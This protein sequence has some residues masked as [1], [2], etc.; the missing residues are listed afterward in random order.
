MGQEHIVRQALG[1]YYSP[2][3]EGKAD[4]VGLYNL[5]YLRDRG[6]ISENLESQYTGYLIEALRSMR[7]GEGSAYGLI[8]SASWNYLM[9]RGALY[10]DP[11][12]GR[13]HMD[14]DKMTPAIRDLAETLLTIEGNGD[15]RPQLTSLI[16]MLR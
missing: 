10:F 14:I 7:F 9:E 3:E 16:T 11:D 4:I 5:V 8:R 12:S 1:E 6:I 15:K 13:F 2:I